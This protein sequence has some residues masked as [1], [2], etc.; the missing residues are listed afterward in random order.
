LNPIPAS[1]MKIDV[2]A[3]TGGLRQSVTPFSSPITQNPLLRR[4]A[5]T[6]APTRRTQ[7]SNDAWVV[8]QGLLPIPD[9]F[10]AAGYVPAKVVPV[11]GITYKVQSPR[12]C[13]SAS[14]GSSMGRKLFAEYEVDP[15]G[16]Q[17]EVDPHGPQNDIPQCLRGS[18]NPQLQAVMHTTQV[19]MRNIRSP[20]C[21]VAYA[22]DSHIVRFSS[23]LAQGLTASHAG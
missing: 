7:D 6:P 16:P 2:P 14:G 17:Y 8:A 19:N 21:F 20:T 3:H 5:L 1:P 4:E 13:H 9:G 11:G 10:V 15:H 18:P 22:T 23:S 12:S